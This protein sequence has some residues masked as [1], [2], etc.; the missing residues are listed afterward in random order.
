MSAIETAFGESSGADRVGRRLLRGTEDS[1]ATV[2]NR[3]AAAEV[4][5]L[6]G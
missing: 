4:F 6:I 5:G 2:E 1:V 3:A